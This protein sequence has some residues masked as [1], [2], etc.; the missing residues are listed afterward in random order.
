[1]SNFYEEHYADPHNI[2]LTTPN[3]K[4]NL[5]MIFAE[6][7]ESTYAYPEYFGDNLIPELS[8]IAKDNINFSDTENLG[9]FKNV[10]GAQYTQA[11]M[12]AQLCAVPFRLPVRAR[13]FHPINGFLPGAVCLSDI[14]KKDDYNQSFMIGMTRQFCGTDSFLETHGNVKILDWDFYSAR[15]NLKRNAD[16]KRRGIVRDINLFKYAKEEILELAS[17]DAPFSFT[18]MTMDTHFGNEHFEKQICSIKYHNDDID[19][20]DNFKNVYSCADQQIS[21]FINWIKVC[22]NMV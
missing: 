22:I 10:I 8:E 7:M 20:E 6:S 4:R 2:E 11:S 21:D 1:M 17:K 18:I 14:L 5:I 13:R 16:K 3:N 19:D 15:D 9:G 12:V